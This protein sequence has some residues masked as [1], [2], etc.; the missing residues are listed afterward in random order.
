MY[1]LARDSWWDNRPPPPPPLPVEEP[2][3]KVP[4]DMSC[5]CLGYFLMCLVQVQH[6]SNPYVRSPGYKKELEAGSENRYLKI[7][8]L[9]TIPA[10]HWM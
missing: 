4:K 7:T 8:H 3:A 6:L 1:C 5:T 9:A 2:P 10:R